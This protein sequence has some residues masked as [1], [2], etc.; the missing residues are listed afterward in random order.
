MKSPTARLLSKRRITAAGCWEYTGQKR[1]SDGYGELSVGGH[2]EMTH[3]VA[4]RLYI[5]SIPPGYYV[6][7]S[8]DNPSCFNPEHLFLGSA[9]DNARD[10]ELKGRRKARNGE[11][12]PMAKLGAEDVHQIRTCGLPASTV[13]R[14]YGVTRQMIWRIRSRRNWRY[15]S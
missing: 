6:C 11:A 8:C 1:N 10:R 4:F 9:A 2:K 5:G 7:H 14:Q 3:R 12:H 15:V 13:A